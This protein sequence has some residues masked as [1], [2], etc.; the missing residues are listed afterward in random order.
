M[1][2]DHG[3]SILNKQEIC[4]IKKSRLL[5][6]R[7]HR[8]SYAVQSFIVDGQKQESCIIIQYKFTV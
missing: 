1:W 3:Q 2:V 8:L 7:I 4:L 5:S 6:A